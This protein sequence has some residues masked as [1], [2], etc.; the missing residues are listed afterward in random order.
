MMD[1]GKNLE[2]IAQIEE[3][4]VRFQQREFSRASKA[5]GNGLRNEALVKDSNNPKPANPFGSSGQQVAFRKSS[6][7]GKR[8]YSER[9][10]SRITILNL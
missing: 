7:E 10:G 5:K 2:A 4:E 1:F 6:L 3:T 8:I 9:V